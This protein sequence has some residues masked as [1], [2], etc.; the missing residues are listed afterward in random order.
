MSK[1]FHKVKVKRITRETDSCVSIEFDIAE[2]MWPLFKYKHG[3]NITIKSPLDDIRRSYSICTSPLEN[4]L[5]IAVKSVPNGVFSGYATE[6]LQPGDELEIMQPTGSF[7]TE[8]DPNQKKHY[9]FFAA[10]SGITPVMSIIKSILVV[11]KESTVALVYGNK[12]VQSIIFKETLEG[13]KDKYLER[14]SVIYI[15]SREQTESEINS[16]RIDEEKCRQLAPLLHYEKADD[17]FICGPEAMIFTVKDFLTGQGITSE[18]IHF[19]LFTTPSSKPTEQKI[20]TKKQSKEES[21]VTVTLDGRT[22]EFGVKYHG[23]TILD[24]GLNLGINLPYSCKAGVCC[25]CRAKV[26]EGAVEMDSNYA[27]EDDE[28]AQ[29]YVLTCQSH[30][31][32]EK[33]VVDYDQ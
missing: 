10:G 17:F 20:I 23:D 25:T 12:N 29:G 24:S 4:K 3:Q 6:K 7:F 2:D 21:Q 13:L 22:Y 11:E 27:L 33:V 26:L 19:E 28:V 18:K 5:T 16:G 8:L 32:T 14:L 1:H 31:R 9:I 15:L 30:P